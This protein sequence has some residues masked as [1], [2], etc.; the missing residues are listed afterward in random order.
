MGQEIR[1]ER[2]YSMFLASLTQDA[3]AGDLMYLNIMGQPILI[4]NSPTAVRDLLVSRGAIYSDR[5]NLEMA[6]RL[7]VLIVLFCLDR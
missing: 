4:L 3:N 1:Y 5:P 2:V 7:Y 6:T